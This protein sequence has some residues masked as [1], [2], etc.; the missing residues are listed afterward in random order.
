MTLSAS[1]KPYF[2]NPPVSL[3]EVGRSKRPV[4]EDRLLQLDPP[5]VVVV[6]HVLE[7]CDAGSCV[8]YSVLCERGCAELEGESTV[9]SRG[10]H[11]PG[12]IV[13]GNPR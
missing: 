9:I 7:V 4:A 10:W 8:E 2:V 5:P 1:R 11:T 6:D 13:V 3:V 12:S